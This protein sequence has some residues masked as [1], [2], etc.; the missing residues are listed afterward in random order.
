MRRSRHSLLAA[1]A[2]M[3]LG[4]CGAG[5]SGSVA[6][7][8]PKAPSNTD[9]AIL[10]GGCFWCVESAF[11]G[12]PGVV[13]AVSGYTGGA[14]P[15]PTYEQVGA[16]GTGHCEAVEVRFDPS[17]IGYAQILDVFWRQIDPTDAGGQFADRGT[18]YRAAIYVRDEAQ[19]RIAEASK[20][21]LEAT[22]WF[23]EP[24]VTM[25]LP[26]GPFY[27]AEEY[28]QDYHAK[29]PA[30]FKAYKWGSGRGPYIERVWKGKPPI[31]VSSETTYTKPSD[32]ELRK[33][34]T[35]LQYEVT[36]HGATEPAFA[37]AYWNNH[38]PGIYVDIV[39]GEPLF[40][41]IDKFDS[42]TGWP[43]FGRPLAREH[44]VQSP[45]DASLM[46]GAEVHSR[47]AG[48]HLG[49]LFAEDSAPTGLRY[50]IDSASLRFI[51]VGK[52]EAEGYGAYAKPFATAAPHPTVQR[53][54]DKTTPQS[55]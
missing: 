35:P 29:H 55:H 12:L 52:L 41:S 9:T 38:E 54:P 34:L 47:D 16:G 28:H 1:L 6:A 18:Q 10:A 27:R 13:D 53:Q 46:L 42:G 14:T 2:M 40:S 30:E 7:S 15:N 22:H 49:H 4:A 19:R 8:A 26:A 32:A 50:C 11:D 21:A 44:V 36:Q 45:G 31:T 33:R 5:D 23:D 25:V 3:L 37:N 51:P 48:S 17:K 20:M 24:I 39:S 43:S